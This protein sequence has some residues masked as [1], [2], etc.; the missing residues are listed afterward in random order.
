MR[1]TNA[2]R[3]SLDWSTQ[4][5]ISRGMLWAMPAMLVFSHVS[6]SDHVQKHV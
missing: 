5:G 3:S 2:T 6:C 1:C 4:I